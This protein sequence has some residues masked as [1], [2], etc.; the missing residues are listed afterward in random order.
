MS[1]G[2]ASKCLSTFLDLVYFSSYAICVRYSSS[3]I[4]A[5][6]YGYEAQSESDPLIDRA[7]EALEISKK[8]MAPERAILLAAFPFRTC[9][10]SV[11]AIHSLTT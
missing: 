6:A 7:H 9:Q 2:S 10:T 4:M 5:A 8:V 1:W 3:L 11:V